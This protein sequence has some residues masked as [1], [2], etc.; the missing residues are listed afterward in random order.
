MANSLYVSA[1]EPFSGKVL[2]SLGLMGVLERTISR[3]GFFRP[4][5]RPYQLLGTETSVID[6]DVHL[7]HEVFQLDGD[8]VE[9]IGV[10]AQEADTMQAEGRLTELHEKILSA[11]KRLEENVEFV[12]SE[13]TDFL[14]AA[15]VTED[16]FNSNVARD[17]NAPVVLVVDG[18]SGNVETVYSKARVGLDCFQ[19]KGCPVLAVVVNKVPATAMDEMDNHILPR[20]HGAGIELVETIPSEPKLATPRMEEVAAHLGGDVLF[21]SK[22]LHNK[23]GKTLVA[24]G[25]VET[26]IQ[27]LA[28]EVVLV[29]HVDR[30]D[31]IFMA[32]ASLM[33]HA[34]PNIG[35][36]VLSGEREITTPVLKLIKGLP[37]P[38]IPIVRSH[39]NTYE[40]VMKL[41][42]VQ[43]VLEPSN[44]RELDMAR[45]IFEAN[46]DVELL[47]EAIQVSKPQQT[48]PTM[49]KYELIRRARS[50]RQ[51]IVLPE[52]K[53]E[54][55]LRAADALLRLQVVD[56]TILGKPK[57]IENHAGQLNLELEGA[58]LIDPNDGP[59]TEEF[60][61]LY[62]KA[63][64]HKGVTLELARETVVEPAVFGTLMV[65]T[66]RADGMVAGATHS[67]AR[68]IRPALEI[69]KTK[70]GY[71]LV[72]SVFFMCLEDRV[73]VYGDCAVNPD[74][75]A[76]ELA[77]IAVA[78]AETAAAFGIDPLVAM[79]SYSTGE[80]GKGAD[81]DKVKEA[82][83]LAKKR[84]PDLKLEGPLQYDAAVDASVA[85][86]KL[87]GSEVGG[88][89]TVFIFPDLN[90]GNNTYK[91]V[92]RSA[93][94]V[95]VGPVLQGLNKPVND[96]SRGCLV[97]DIVN[98]VAIT[99]IQAQ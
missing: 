76:S 74:P 23:V 69:I 33:S 17:L 96:L 77:D 47:T 87:P 66:G 8:P 26:I 19:A 10:T 81:V 12:L 58:Q 63:R 98:T 94:A 36:I 50:D 82:V 35:G 68:T 32:L 46:V 39:L 72:S 24:S 11:Y 2:V 28:N 54:R 29:T 91:A 90:T 85:K 20:L 13:G 83:R 88:H 84:R 65:H 5:G 9:M 22:H 78:S 27:H 31:V 16:D 53:D 62:H 92:Q 6:R 25:S 34:A 95:A 44:L 41:S 73:L 42:R 61:A 52:G 48:T 55:I 79:L 49:F 67:T 99:A 30:H 40:T 64:Q 89:A 57:E 37:G 45:Q 97:E 1:A 43:A 71:S 56:L 70:R 3:L 59:W 21:G 4:V 86:S 18:S 75:T 38:R 51:H 93:H 80:S 15:S 60:A 14:S 7:M